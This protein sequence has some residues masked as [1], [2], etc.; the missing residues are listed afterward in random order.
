[1]KFRS[2]A[3]LAVLFAIGIGT[4]APAL[5]E[6]SQMLQEPV[7]DVS[8]LNLRDK[9]LAVYTSRDRMATLVCRATSPGGDFPEMEVYVQIGRHL[10]DLGRYRGITRVSWKGSRTVSFDATKLVGP[11]VDEV[12]TVT[13]IV[14]ANRLTREV[15]RR[16]QDQPSG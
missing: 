15:L 12:G 14:G 9:P 8:G 3:R 10:F 16:E 1:M 6:A 13:Y 2:L 5:A 7:R 4:A 11:G